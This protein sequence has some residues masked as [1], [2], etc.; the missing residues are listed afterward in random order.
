MQEAQSDDRYFKISDTMSKVKSNL[1]RVLQ[2]TVRNG[3][4]LFLNHAL[5]GA[6]RLSMPLVSVR[7]ESPKG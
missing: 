5:N 7:Y 2:L 1:R 3:Q 4:R 6:V